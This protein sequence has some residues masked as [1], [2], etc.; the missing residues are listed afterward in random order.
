MHKAYSKKSGVFLNNFA[1]GDKYEKIK[2]YNKDDKL[3][4]KIAKKGHLKYHKY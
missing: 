4:R 1:L 2:K 3:W